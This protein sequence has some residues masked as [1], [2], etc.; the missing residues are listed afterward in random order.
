[1]MNDQK[2]NNKISYDAI[3][4]LLPPISV[5]VPVYNEEQGVLETVI[6]MLKEMKRLNIKHEIICVDDGSSDKS[7]DILSNLSKKETN[8]KIMKHPYNMG[9]GATLK[10]GIKN[11]QY[12]WILIIDADGSYPVKELSELLRHLPTYDVV[13]GA[14]I[15]KS[16]KI[17][18]VRKFPKWLL[19]KF[20]SYLAG[21][22]IPDLNSGFRIFKKDIA[23][24]YWHF[25]P[26]GFSFTSTLT[27]AAFAELYKVKFVPIS[28]E[29]RIGKSSIKPLQDTVKFFTLVL[30]LTAYFNPMKV[31][32]PLSIT[33]FL[34]ALA[35]GIRDIIV[36]SHLGG[37][38]L[39]LFILSI[40]FFFFGV[41]MD[42]LCKIAITRHE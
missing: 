17:P 30:T 20:A 41:I 3:S 29:K 35:R 25:F 11:S 5:V 12:N 13:I 23:L 1:M 31:F 37:L 36:E 21:R 40:Q 7:Y 32:L 9:Y 42:I 27:M 16:A 28:Y 19:N 10:T 8:L 39:I 34:F 4:E 6:G 33:F 24:K 38:C 26:P 14:R 18:F 15:K 2:L 22:P